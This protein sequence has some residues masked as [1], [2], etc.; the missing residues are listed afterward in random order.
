MQ[1]SEDLFL[2]SAQATN[3]GLPPLRTNQP[4]PE[5]N[6]IGPMGRIYTK[7]IVPLALLANNIALSQ[8]PGAGGNLVLTAGAGVTASVIPG[9]FN[10]MYVLDTPRAIRIVNG[11]NEAGKTFTITGFDDY[12]QPMVETIA[13]AGAGTLT[14]KK[15]WKYIVSVAISAAAAGTLTVGTTDIFGL[16][17]ALAGIG[18]I[19]SVKWDNV[20][21]QNAATVVAADATSPATTN[22]GD[23]RGTV[24]QAG[25]PSDGV[26]RLLVAQYTPA[27]Q[28]GPNATRL[29]ALGVNQ[30]AG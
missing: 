26:R 11:G 14:G 2:G 30:F 29:G 9:T 16:N 19:F 18:Y 7:D 5:A 20:L 8:T 15:A 28:A 4:S 23:V 6:G 17:I 10:A 25:N 24:A 22:G 3:L 1:I 27:I 13:G 12:G 21:A